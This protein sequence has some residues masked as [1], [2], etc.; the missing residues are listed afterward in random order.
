MAFPGYG[1][2]WLPKTV[3]PNLDIMNV[4]FSKQAITASVK[5]CSTPA[6]PRRRV[7]VRR[8]LRA[9]VGQSARETAGCREGRSGHLTRYGDLTSAGSFW[10]VEVEGCVPRNGNWDC[11]DV[12][13]GD[14]T[15]SPSQYTGDLSPTVGSRRKPSPCDLLN[16]KA[17]RRLKG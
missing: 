6:A 1:L 7:P 16:R 13:I 14:G 5:V 2:H 9:G 17:E 15:R 10:N 11:V 8:C 12:L 3:L 4:R